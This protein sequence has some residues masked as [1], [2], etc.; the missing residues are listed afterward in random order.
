MTRPEE[1]AP[2]PGTILVRHGA[3][4][5]NAAGRLQGWTDPDLSPD[6]VRQARR[7]GRLV[8]ETGTR[9]PEVWSSDLTRA[10]RTAELAFPGRPVRTDS[11]LREMSFGRWE[12][13]SWEEIRAAEA[14]ALL[15]W[16]RNPEAVAPPGG[17][18]LARLRARVGSWVASRRR[19][20]GGS[21]VV[22]VAH[23]G[24]LR[25]LL[26]RFLA[27][28]A[29]WSVEGLLRLPPGGVVRLGGLP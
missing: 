14:E 28:P 5:L 26:A 25:L 23:G 6:G 10:R 1:E 4:A 19:R 20:S 16:R 18:T 27:L 11:R 21:S 2:W 17:E 3:T 9:S 8:R 29:D 12:G 15:R 7:A 13:R 22:V 24:P